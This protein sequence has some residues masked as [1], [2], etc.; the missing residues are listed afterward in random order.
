MSVTV[1]NS[2]KGCRVW[3]CPA[4]PLKKLHCVYKGER[5][6]VYRKLIE[7]ISDLGILNPILGISAPNLRVTT[8]KQRIEACRYLGIEEVPIVIWDVGNVL[9]DKHGEWSEIQTVAEGQDLFADNYKFSMSSRG[10]RKE[11]EEEYE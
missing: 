4:Y 5:G 11:L 6:E 10:F 9:P 2:D 8:G 7:S 3:Y 1:I